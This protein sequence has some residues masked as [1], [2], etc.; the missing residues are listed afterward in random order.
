MGGMRVGRNTLFKLVFV[1][2]M[3]FLAIDIGS[4]LVLSTPEAKATSG[5]QYKVVSA[6]M[7]KTCAQYED[8]LNEMAS[9]GWVFDH[10]IEAADIAVFKK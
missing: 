9:Q 7:I 2:A 1:I 5:V 6:K 3:L 4:R 8:L 10:F